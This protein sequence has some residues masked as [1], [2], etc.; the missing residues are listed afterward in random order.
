MFLTLK[1]EEF[2]KSR[3]SI[4]EITKL[5]NERFQKSVCRK[6]IF[7]F[8]HNPDNY[9][10]KKPTGRPRRI[11]ERSRR[12]IID[13]STT[14]KDSDFKSCRKIASSM[15]NS[16][17]ISI[18]KS[19]VQR[20]LNDNE[21]VEYSYITPKIYLTKLHKKNRVA[22]C[23]NLLLNPP[24]WLNIIWSDEKKFSLDGPD[25]LS[26]RWMNTHR[27]QSGEYTRMRR[28][29][30]GGGLM[31]WAA[32]TGTGEKMIDVIEGTLNSARYIELLGEHIVPLITRANEDFLY[33]HDNAPPHRAIKTKEFLNRNNIDIMDWAA[34]S[35]DLNPMENVW[36]L[37]VSRLYA[38]N[39]QYT[40]KSDLKNSILK[41]WSGIDSNTLQNL[42][43][44]IPERLINVIE[45][46][47]D[48]V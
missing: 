15:T 25:G 31:I 21:D 7:R 41:I 45:K 46:G 30:A 24:N 28:H 40:S 11:S 8:L 27:K 6:T 10:R 48:L 18:S 16:V 32:F 34:K 23:K 35:P 19:H 44:S 3:T 5:F 13:M 1:Y 47:G 26:K 20:I 36:A 29:S 4:T 37:I 22:M 38:A 2:E 42:A 12:T 9:D 43:F 14:S 39:K 33:Q 17:G